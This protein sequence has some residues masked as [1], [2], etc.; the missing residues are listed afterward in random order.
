MRR[1][2]AGADTPPPGITSAREY[3]APMQYPPRELER[4][5]VS[6]VLVVPRHRSAVTVPPRPD[7]PGSSA[8]PRRRWHKNPAPLSL[9]ATAW[10]L[11][12]IVP[13]FSAAS[14]RA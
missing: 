13:S 11:G 14:M 3:P 2:R 5:E 1:R 7:R 12:D 4:D 10:K 6:R 9:A 8:R